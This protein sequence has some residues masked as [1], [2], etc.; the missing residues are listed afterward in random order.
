MPFSIMPSTSTPPSFFSLKVDDD[1]L[2]EQLDG[3]L[4]LTITQSHREM[5]FLAVVISLVLT[6]AFAL[7]LHML[8]LSDTIIDLAF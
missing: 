5:S 4:T 2:K 1:D 8:T 3:Y 6:F 7:H